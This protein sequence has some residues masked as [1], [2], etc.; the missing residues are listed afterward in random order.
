MNKRIILAV[1]FATILTLG[2][3]LF[4]KN[5]NIAT[6]PSINTSQEQS[7]ESVTES[8]DKMSA[9]SY[10][11]SEVSSHATASDCWLIIQD[12]VYDVSKFIPMHPGGEEILKGCGKDATSMFNSRPTDGTAH[13]EKANENLEN[14]LIGVLSK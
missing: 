10:T 11:L 12:N 9:K 7:S 2:F 14:F 3:Y 4:T 6:Q 8:D 5:Q 13:S 1:A